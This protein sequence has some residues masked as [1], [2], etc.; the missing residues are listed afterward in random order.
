MVIC[1][2]LLLL[3][4]FVLFLIKISM[5]VL[6][7]VLPNRVSLKNKIFTSELDSSGLFKIM[8]LLHCINAINKVEGSYKLN[9]IYDHVIIKW[10]HSKLMTSSRFLIGAEIFHVSTSKN[11]LDLYLYFRISS[12]FQNIYVVHDLSHHRGLTFKLPM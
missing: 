10:Q 2:L 3:L 9:R 1:N 8:N 11:F 12:C 5:Y 4:F 6:F 7:H